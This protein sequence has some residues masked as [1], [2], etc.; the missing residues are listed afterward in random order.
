MN[1]IYFVERKKTLKEKNIEWNHILSAINIAS[2]HP[3][4]NTVWIICSRSHFLHLYMNSFCWSCINR[5]SM[6]FAE[7]CIAEKKDHR[8]LTVCFMRLH[9]SFDDLSVRR[10]HFRQWGTHPGRKIEWQDLTRI[11]RLIISDLIRSD[12]NRMQNR[13]LRFLTLIRIRRSLKDSVT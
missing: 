2:I 8:K 1:G 4:T 5:V 9:G 3:F 6:L 12:E 11:I 13:R 10:S 7:N